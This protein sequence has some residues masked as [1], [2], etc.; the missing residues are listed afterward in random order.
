MGE[1]TRSSAGTATVRIA[2]AY[3]DSAS[4]MSS[5]RWRGPVVM[6]GAVVLLLAGLA[7]WGLVHRRVG[8]VNR[9]RYIF[10][11]ETGDHRHDLAFQMSLQLAEKR[12]AIENA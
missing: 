7:E 1:S 8:A 10:V 11:N 2:C 12:S 9:P 4:S 3:G 5:R 6:L